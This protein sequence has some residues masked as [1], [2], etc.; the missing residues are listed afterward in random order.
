MEVSISKRAWILLWICLVILNLMMRIP[1]TPHQIGHDSFLIHFVAE[2]IS[3][4]GTAKWWIHPLSIIGLYP[5]S[6]ASAL[7]FYLSGLSQI[8]PL[9]MEQAIWFALIVLG[10][11]SSFTAYLMAGAI[12]D[13]KLFKFITALVYST[14]PGILIQTTWS[15]SGRGLF[16]VLLPLFIYFLIKSRF[17]K[18]IYLLF[19]VLLFLLLLA[20][21][22][23]FYFLI[24]I[25]LGCA[26]AL[27]FSNIQIKSSNYYGGIVLLILFIILYIQL[28]LEKVPIYTLV[29]N[30]SRYI[31]V[32]GIFAIGGFIS[33]LFKKNNTFEENFIIWN[34][35]FFVPFFSVLTYFKFFMLPFEAL[36]V[37]YGIVN[38]IRIP[39]K[40]KVV[41]SVIMVIIILSIGIAEFY[42]FGRTNINEDEY[43]QY[44]TFWAEES[45]V[46]AALWA[47]SYT[48]KLIYIDDSMI[49]RRILAYSGA[50]ILSESNVVLPIQ[51]NLED[52]NLS[53]RSPFSTS[54]Y[55]EGP[56]H[57]DE[58]SGLKQFVW[59]KLRDEGLDSKWE[60]L[61]KKYNITYYIKY[62]KIVTVFSRSPKIQEN[63]KLF[64]NGDISI[65]NLKI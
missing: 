46:N 59:F 20:T 26:T 12:K 19:T 50:T 60:W 24:P 21:H 30:Y 58:Q 41:L 6:M 23:L 14:S 45:T 3:T 63:N 35:L 42:Q 33:I 22:N 47:K 57:V 1:L 25:I 31:G 4:Y 28:S 10:I 36:L 5:F 29:Y 54:F 55:S 51:D 2:S 39:Q 48:N 15:A 38:L 34:I 43:R 65:W 44:R 16:L 18:I 56:F 11:F 32:L 13:D 64:D 52:F 49:S 62:D 37:S 8:L 53:M 27:I 9:T 40:R 17:S 7:P 61:L